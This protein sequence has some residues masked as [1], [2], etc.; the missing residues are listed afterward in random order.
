MNK[1]QPLALLPSIDDNN[2]FRGFWVRLFGRFI[3]SARNKA[4]L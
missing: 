3:E 1:Q 4:G 2:Y